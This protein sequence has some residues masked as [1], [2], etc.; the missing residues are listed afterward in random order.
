MRKLSPETSVMSLGCSYGDIT[1]NQVSSSFAFQLLSSI[2]W[3][4]HLL[5]DLHDALRS[6]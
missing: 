4:L 3:Q 1:R 5:M 6:L 2:F